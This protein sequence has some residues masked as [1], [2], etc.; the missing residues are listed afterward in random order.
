LI[1]ITYKVSFMRSFLG[2]YKAQPRRFSIIYNTHVRVTYIH[3]VTLSFLIPLAS[4]AIP[5][6]PS[7]VLP[8]TYLAPSSCDRTVLPLIR[9]LVDWPHLPLP[10]PINPFI[11]GSRNPNSSAPDNDDIGA[12]P[13]PLCGTLPPQSRRW[14]L[15]DAV[16]LWH[17]PPWLGKSPIPPLFVAFVTRVVTQ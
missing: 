3:G 2:M 1:I 17:P 12:T 5:F 15:R 10:S 14:I 16:E 13:L 9:L 4:F 6:L 8:L 7:L 11:P